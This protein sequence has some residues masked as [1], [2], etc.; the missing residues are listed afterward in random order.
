MPLGSGLPAMKSR[1]SA[2]PAIHCHTRSLASLGLSGVMIE[3]TAGLPWLTDL[4]S[5]LSAGTPGSS[6]DAARVGRHRV[7]VVGAA[8][9]RLGQQLRDESGVQLEVVDAAAV[10]LGAIAS[11]QRLLRPDLDVVGEAEAGD[12][13]RRVHRGSGRS[14]CS[15]SGCAEQGHVR[16]VAGQVGPARCVRDL[17]EVEDRLG[18][19]TEAVCQRV[20]A[21]VAISLP[22]T[23]T[24]P[25]LSGQLPP[26]GWKP[27][28]NTI[29]LLPVG[30]ASA[31]RS[32]AGAAFRRR[33]GSS[34]RLV[35]STSV[36]RTRY[37]DQP[38]AAARPSCRR[39]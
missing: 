28:G 35:P 12:G 14:G 25:A 3:L 30:R 15:V 39:L 19:L 22:S 10:E 20:T 9:V 37:H 1:A 13:D 18:L 11:G 31:V 33:L 38:A 6:L 32:A 21:S 8:A 27:R 7:R 5:G 34:V 4:N 36:S 16:A 29:F 17:V 2:S 24:W 26:I 23:V